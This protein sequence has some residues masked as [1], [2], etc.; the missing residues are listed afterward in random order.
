MI[1]LLFFGIALC[2][3]VYGA[4]NGSL[5]SLLVATVMT[6]LGSVSLYTN[7]RRQAQAQQAIAGSFAGNSWLLVCI[8]AAFLASLATRRALDNAFDFTSGYFWLAGM[9]LAVLAAY[10]HDYYERRRISAVAAAPQAAT[11]GARFDRLDWLLIGLITAV[12]LYL[13]LHNLTDFLPTMHGDE[14]EMGMLALLALHGPASGFSPM[15][16]P[17]FS[18]AF[19][20]HPTLFHYLQAGALWLFG[21]SLYGLRAL[22]AI[23]GALCVPVVYAIGRVGWGRIAAV[24]AGWLLAVSHFH[25]QYSRIA[26]NNVETIWFLALFIFLLLLAAAKTAPQPRKTS[27]AEAQEPVQPTPAPLTP[28][29]WA[30]LCMGLSQYFYYGSRLIP[31][32]AGPLLLVL[33]F[34]RRLTVAQVIILAVATFVAYAPL[35]GHYSQSLPAFLNRTKGVSVISPEGMAHT[36]GPQAVWPDDIPQ[37][38][39]EQIRR[40]IAFF[41]YDGDRSAFY[42]TDLGAFDPIT[43][44]LFWLGLGV[45]LARIRRFE[46]FTI[47]L[48]WGVGLL[49]AGVVTNDAPNGPRLVVITTSV[50]VIGGI[51]LQ[52]AFNFVQS[53]WPAGSRWGVLYGGLLL[54]AVTLQL[55]YTTYFTTYAQYT[56]NTL[57]I[58]M[59]HE[60]RDWGAAYQVYLFGAP[61]LYADYSTLRFIALGTERYNAEQAEQLPAPVELETERRGLLAIFLPHR[62]ADLEQVMARFPGGI[63]TEQVDRVGNLLY[64]MYRIPE[65]SAVADNHEEKSEETNLTSLLSSP[66]QT[67]AAA[68]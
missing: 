55:N 16:L 2:A 22:S 65:P 33:W 62:L 66:L 52:R 17:L 49:L 50:Y 53:V 42:M 1:H 6:L 29:L 30:G 63:R 54:A 11:Q 57:A 23:F 38:V 46:E 58:R 45:L 51:F 15:P 34:K 59:A 25:L 28:Y 61:N 14:G 56:P 36:L 4:L 20:D 64:I 37:L 41:A 8:V 7:P 19:L 32:L 10:G 9:V 39:W 44:A 21:E 12:A 31:V 48:W 40:N 43:I 67:P 35:A 60:I 3:S 26:L 5:I 27:A 13:R 47:F 24:T 18:T 68:P